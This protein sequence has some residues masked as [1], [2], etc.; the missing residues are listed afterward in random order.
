MMMNISYNTYY[1]PS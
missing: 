1:R